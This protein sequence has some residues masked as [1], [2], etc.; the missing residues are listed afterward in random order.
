VHILRIIVR[1]R[2][3]MTPCIMTES[4]KKLIGNSMADCIYKAMWGM[5]VYIDLLNEQGLPIPPQNPNPKILIQNEQP[6][7]VSV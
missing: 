4:F 5:K 7:K 3:Y 6:E 2:R 1:V